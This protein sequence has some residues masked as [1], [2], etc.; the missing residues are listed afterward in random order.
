MYIKNTRNV[1][2]TYLR[3]LYALATTEVDNNVYET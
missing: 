3:L 1:Q 2:A